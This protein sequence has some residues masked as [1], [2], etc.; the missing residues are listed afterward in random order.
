VRVSVVGSSGAGKTTFGRRLAERLGVPLIE[1]DAIYHQ[2]GWTVL[3][4]DEFRLEVAEATLEGAWVCDGNYAAVR[5]IVWERATDVVWIDPPKAVVI[6]QVIGRS[7]SRVV[8]RRE[9]WNGNRERMRTWVDEEHPIRWSWS[10]FD[11][12]RVEY[13]LRLALAENAHLRV[14]KLKSRRA[15]RRFLDQV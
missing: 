3:S 13:P 6:V 2:A 4:D 15:A 10:T 5:P 7:I 8:T 12:K 14:H 9:L 11:R 1:L